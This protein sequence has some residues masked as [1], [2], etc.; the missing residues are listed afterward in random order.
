MTS[1]SKSSNISAKYMFKAF[2]E[3][4]KADFILHNNTVEELESET[5]SALNRY[6]PNYAIGSVSLSEASSVAVGRS[7]HA[8]VDITKWLVSKP[9]G[10]VLYVSFGSVVR[11]SK[12]VIEEIAH[13]LRLSEVNFIWVA[14]AH[15][16]AFSDAKVLPDGF[17][18]CISRERK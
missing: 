10:S 9:A 3:V 5:L 11:T 13:G 7:L 17:E 15:L 2:E 16:T 1:L 12:E 14:R 6:Q 18:E 8:E 4:K